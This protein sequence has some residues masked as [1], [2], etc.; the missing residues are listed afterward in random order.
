MFRFSFK[1]EPGCTT[2]TIRTRY[3][4]MYWLGI[5]AYWLICQHEK[6]NSRYFNFF[7][8]LEVQYCTTVEQ[9]VRPVVSVVLVGS[10]SNLFFFLD[11][12][13]IDIDLF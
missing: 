3:C 5:D 8:V 12:T 13:S 9:F 11:R 1:R 10:S 6:Y 4:T 7:E 2:D